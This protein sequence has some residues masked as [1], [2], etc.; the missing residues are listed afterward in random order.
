MTSI[1]SRLLTADKPFTAPYTVPVPIQRPIYSQSVTSSNQV[2]APQHNVV[3]GNEFPPVQVPAGRRKKASRKS[4]DT[5]VRFGRVPKREKAKILA[6][7]QKVNANS[8]EKALDAELEDEFRLMNTI[9]R[10]HSETCDYTKEKV[11]GLVEKARNQPVYTQCPPQLACPL[12]PAPHIL[13][14]GASHYMEDFSERFAPAIKGVVEFAKR[15]P[16]FGFLSQDDQVTLLKAGVFEVLLVRL[17]C[18]FDSQANSL[19]CLNGQVLRRES[20]HSASNARFL[21]D[22]MF[23]FAERLN[24]LRLSD[25][26]VGLFCA[27]VVIAADR[28]G[29]RNT[30][31]VLKVQ[32]KM[33]DILQKAVTAKHLENPNIFS[34]LMKKIPDLRTLNTLHSEKLLA[35]KMEP[36]NRRAVGAI[37]G[38]ADNSVTNQSA[39]SA[40]PHDIWSTYS[41]VAT[42][43]PCLAPEEDMRSTSPGQHSQ[44]GGSTT[45][46]E[47]S[48]TDSK[49]EHDLVGSPRSIGSGLCVDDVKSPIRSSSFSSS[50]SYV[51][52]ETW[53]SEPNQ[54][55]VD[56]HHNLPKR[57]TENPG[58]EHG[59]SSGDEGY[60][61]DS[62]IK[63]PIYPKL[64]RVDSPTDSGI[65]SGKEHGPST[66]PTIS[67]CS[68]PR[69]SVDEKVKDMDHDHHIQEKHDTIEDMPVLKRALQAP[70][71]I[72]PHMLM[73]EAYRHHKKFRAARREAES[74][75]SPSQMS[76]A[77]THSTLVRTLEQAPR[78]LSEQQLKR[79]DLI[80]N[81]IMQKETLPGQQQP[82]PTQQH[83]QN[84]QQTLSQSHHADTQSFS[85]PSM[86]NNHYPFSSVPN[87]PPVSPPSSTYTASNA[88]THKNLLVCP[89]GYYIPQG[90]NVQQTSIYSS[91][92]P[93]SWQFTQQSSSV[94]TVTSASPVQVHTQYEHSSHMPQNSPG[95]HQS[96]TTSYCSSPVVNTSRAGSPRLLYNPRSSPPTSTS[97]LVMNGNGLSSSNI[98]SGCPSDTRPVQTEAPYKPSGESQ[99]LNLSKK[100]FS[101]PPML[102]IES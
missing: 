14:N 47:W 35:Y 72:N 71:I 52:E 66:T 56:Y 8:Q 61:I 48:T 65:E 5:P 59:S 94:A 96:N 18:M 19:I 53:P 88:S 39:Y 37:D 98:P 10:A 95:S 74:P 25:S 93:V 100:L 54:N 49:D 32:K 86:Q 89:N 43:P 36:C 21:L 29:L 102:K 17:A 45:G 22:S 60:F 33:M 84:H 7:M 67:V 12:N 11:V 90:G 44:H 85:C 28:P 97:P 41:L 57:S 27:V 38:I 76:L 91:V 34:D 87:P 2:L 26:E 79:T 51:N 40:I 31:L 3:S 4:Q 30:D 82:S 63:G 69:S 80:H 42:H 70:P 55:V 20:L 75:A 62:P 92:T 16:G 23:D 81:I 46:S 83:Q 9:I 68:S 50:R 101:P 73:D 77:S 15:I 58:S 13:E 1:L 6:A 99:P 64:R 78:Y 24:T